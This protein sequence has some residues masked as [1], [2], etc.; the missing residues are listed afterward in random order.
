MV[1]EDQYVNRLLQFAADQTGS[2]ATSDLLQAGLDALG[3]RLQAVN[4]LASRGV[5][6]SVPPEEAHSCFAQTYLLSAKILRI[7]DRTSGGL[8]HDEADGPESADISPGT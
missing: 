4:A 5:H 6:S 7:R 1:G 2:R 3:R 8:V